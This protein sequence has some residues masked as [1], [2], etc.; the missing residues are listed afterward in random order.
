M[1]KILRPACLMIIMTLVLL[2]VSTFT[3]ALPAAA[4]DFEYETPIS[5]TASTEHSGYPASSAIDGSTIPEDSWFSDG[6]ESAPQWIYFDLGE[7]KCINAVK[8]VIYYSDVPLTMDVQV[9]DDASDWTT[10]VE[11]WTVTVGSY[12]GYV[13]WVEKSFDETTGRYIRLYQTNYNRTHGTCTEFQ[14]STA[15]ISNAG[16]SFTASPTMGDAP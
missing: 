3:L 1:T 16:A 7:N 8:V 5:A 10:V 6:S 11:D 12:T 4:D 15:P 2:L 13:Y 14:A 9:S